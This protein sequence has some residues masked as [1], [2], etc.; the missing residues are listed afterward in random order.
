MY[1][2]SHLPFVFGQPFI[3]NALQ[4]FGLEGEAPLVSGI[5]TAVMMGVSILTSWFAPGIKERIGLLGILLVAF[6]MQ[7]AIAAGLAASGS[8]LVV[9]LL[10]LRMVPDSFSRPFILART[11]PLLSDETR[12]T[13]LS[14]K[15]LAG[16]L[17]FA[18]TL[19]MAST[20][21]S[22]VGAMSH[23]EIRTILSAYAA[24]G[25]IALLVL[26]IAAR[27]RGVSGP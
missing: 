1:G 7:I 19:W 9:A 14:I 25:L 26:A 3:L 12:A 2:Y 21:A 18:A 10:L 17:F 8:I 6:G 15:S 20:K 22:E 4:T 5:V 23:G 16:R 13:Y 24:F 11:Q 27:G